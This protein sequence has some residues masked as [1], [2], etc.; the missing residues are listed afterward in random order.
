MT[1]KETITSKANPRVKELCATRDHPSPSSFLIEGKHMVDMAFQRGLLDQVIA[2][3]PVDYPGV[4]TLSVSREVLEK[5]APSKTPSG[6]LGIA[7]AGLE[8]K[9]GDYLLLDRVQDPGNVG[10]LLRSALSFGFKK[11][12]VLPGTASP[13]SSKALASSQGA[14][15][16]LDIRL[17]KEGPSTLMSLSAKGVTVLGTSLRNAIPIS[18]YHRGEGDIALLLGNEGRGV[19]EELLGLCSKNLYIEMKEMES[20]NVGVAG[21]IAMYLLKR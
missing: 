15:F 21:G 8:K 3:V 4:D 20:L 16:G 14:I 17:C 18:S 13:F 9:E 10:T 19:S 7:H 12:Y 11:V 6:I 5:I 2:S 1:M